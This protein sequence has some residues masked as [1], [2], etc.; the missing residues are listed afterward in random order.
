M[1]VVNAS[2]HDKV[3]NGSMWLDTLSGIW[4]ESVKGVLKRIV[5]GS[6]E[7]EEAK[8]IVYTVHGIYSDAD[9]GF[10][11]TTYNTY[12]DKPHFFWVGTNHSNLARCYGV[13]NLDEIDA[14][15][16]DEDF[17]TFIEEYENVMVVPMTV[18]GGKVIDIQYNKGFKI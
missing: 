11:Y 4:Y 10:L 12:E 8:A 14:L 5:P 9:D 7:E 3:K 18:V 15:I 6:E 16:T 13:I 2:I 1:A 17:V